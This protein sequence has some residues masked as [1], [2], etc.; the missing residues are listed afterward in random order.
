ML[1]WSLP[2]GAAT[3][4]VGPGEAYPT[5]SAV[6]W[7]SLAAGDLVL[8]N[9]RAE[10]YRDKW[11]ITRQ[12]AEGA[13][14]VVRGVPGP[15]G[16]LPVIDG[17]G[18]VTRP[19]LNYW[20]TNRGVIKIGGARVPSD[21]MPRYIVIE[22]LDVRGAHQAY[23]FTNSAGATERYQDQAAAIWI[24]KGE[25]ITLRGNHL[26]DSGNGLFVSS[27][28]PDVS[29]SILVEGNAVYDN[30]N[31]GRIFEHNIYTEALGIT[32]QFNYLGPLKA[33]ALGNNLKDRSG[34]FVARYNWIYSGNRQLDLVESDSPII[35]ADATYRSTFVY[36]NVL[37][38]PPGAGNRQ[39]VHYGGDNGQTTIYR[40]GT[41]HFYN[42]TVVSL[43]PDSTTLFR[44]S[45]ND[46]HVDARNN[47]FYTSA[48]GA[49]LSVLDDTGIFD[50]SRNW[51]KSGIVSV[52]GSLS[53]SVRDDGSS[54]L[55]IDPGFRD[56]AAEDFRPSA[57]SPLV[58]AGGALAEVALPELTIG[59]EYVRHLGARLRPDDGRIDIGAFE[60]EPDPPPAL[61]LPETTTQRTR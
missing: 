39:I 49:T 32:F 11:V 17:N 10:P 56:V 12:G 54:F 24:E 18:A 27:V 38:E 30:G 36:G 28:D 25:H 46:E 58:N 51:F 20:G 41:L 13:P 26:H 61:S 53:G 7:E 59:W 16:E 57:T 6:P 34:A 52:F 43:R 21:T 4:V 8:I 9:W 33:G 40:K 29:R 15:L 60:W 3:Y 55:G 19:E 44:L 37:I 31:A 48:V 45:T 22:G 5:P 50:S 42:N 47:I 1:A 14:I 35:R 2:A 23:T